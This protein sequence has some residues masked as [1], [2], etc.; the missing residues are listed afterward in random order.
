LTI[1]SRE[2]LDQ[3]IE[4]VI[5]KNNRLI[6][7]RGTAVHGSL[8]GIIMKSVRGRVDAGLVSERLKKHLEK[9]QSEPS[10]KKSGDT[11]VN[12]E[13]EMVEEGMDEFMDNATKR[14]KRGRRYSG[15]YKGRGKYKE[16]DI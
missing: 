7:T 12:A 13:E 6:E 1:I 8:M 15:K 2:E 5:K 14:K 10:Q 4:E 9:K 11:P 16:K 3:L